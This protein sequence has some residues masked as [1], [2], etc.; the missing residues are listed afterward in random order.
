MT[1]DNTTSD[2]KEEHSE[3]DQ[4]LRELRR[5]GGEFPVREESLD[6]I[7]RRITP[8]RTSP[9]FRMKVRALVHEGVD[10]RRLVGAT[11]AE[12]RAGAGLES[13]ALA[14]RLDVETA[15]L[16]DLEAGRTHPAHF[17]ADFWHGFAEA[18]ATPKGE[19]ARFLAGT[20]SLIAG[21]FTRV[22]Q[23]GW[24]ADDHAPPLNP[25]QIAAKEAELRARLAAIVE[26]LSAA[27]Q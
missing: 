24:A 20:E 25:D 5:A 11:I 22:V 12:L 18:V 4:L 16:Q 27:D 3:L 9:A 26:E 6:Q 14:A 17:I 7:W 19:L 21:S 8:A 1:P 10:A 23:P 13:G 15:A 2:K